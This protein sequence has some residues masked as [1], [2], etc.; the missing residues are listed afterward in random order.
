MY[1]FLN[2]GLNETNGGFQA[3]SNE[4]QGYN[5]VNGYVVFLCAPLLP[6][7]DLFCHIVAV[8][9]KQ[10]Q[11]IFILHRGNKSLHRCQF[12]QCSEKCKKNEIGSYIL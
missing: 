9:Y 2:F 1:N 10:Y 8:P 11:I 12:H 4:N 7:S 3:T 6:V 5:M